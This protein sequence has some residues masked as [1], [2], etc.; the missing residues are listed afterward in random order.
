MIKSCLYAVLLLLFPLFLSAQIP[1]DS[2][3]RLGDYE[4]QRASSYAGWRR[5]RLVMSANRAESWAWPY[6]DQF[7]TLSLSGSSQTCKLRHVCATRDRA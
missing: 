6:C 7:C 3:P 1:L 4:S 2:L 5:H